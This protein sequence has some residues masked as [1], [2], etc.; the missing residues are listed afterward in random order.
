MIYKK[1]TYCLLKTIFVANLLIITIYP[2]RAFTQES[3]EYYRNNYTYLAWTFRYSIWEDYWGITEIDPI[4][5]KTVSVTYPI[6][7]NLSI[8]FSMNLKDD[9]ESS[10]EDIVGGIKVGRLTT[11]ISKGSRWGTLVEDPK[12]LFNMMVPDSLEFLDETFMASIGIYSPGLGVQLPVD[13]GIG[14]ARIKHPVYHT[15]NLN[16]END[17][18]SEYPDYIVDR[19][20]ESYI[21]GWWVHSDLLKEI[22]LE[23]T[24]FVKGAYTL[25]EDEKSI[26]AIGLAMEALVGYSWC[27]PSQSAVQMIERENTRIN[28]IGHELELKAPTAHGLGFMGATN[29]ELAA[30][31]HVR[32]L[33]SIGFLVGFDLRA[34]GNM[35][36][37]DLMEE[38]DPGIIQLQVEGLGEYQFGPYIRIA[39]AR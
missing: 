21:V 38:P 1:I 24:P 11:M 28:K 37:T 39:F 2:L 36:L 25:Y 10:L 16:I 22:L 34:F 29:I 33:F 31:Y 4:L 9:F 23:G 35:F 8:D 30:L 13:R 32:D 14:Y 12:E 6:S 19:D 18:Y 20:F 5:Y 27:E 26:I 7:Q 17:N 15:V 3:D